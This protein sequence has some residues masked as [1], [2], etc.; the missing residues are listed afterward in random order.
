MVHRLAALLSLAM[1]AVG[2]C[3]CAN[4]TSVSPSPTTPASP[5]YASPAPNLIGVWSFLQL[6][7]LSPAQGLQLNI[8]T[9]LPDGRLE[10]TLSYYANGLL[11][12][13]MQVSVSGAVRGTQIT[14][15]GSN[16]SFS[17]TY[18]LAIGASISFTA[19]IGSTTFSGQLFKV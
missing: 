11:S 7:G 13:T 15:S 19:L 18:S 10:G 14:L 9:Q 4:S 1:L 5:V 3:A 2:I 17:G 8:T 16:T 12:P 6:R